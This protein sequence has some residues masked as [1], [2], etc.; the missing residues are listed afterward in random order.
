MA[1]KAPGRLT[2]RR[3]LPAYHVPNWTVRGKEVRLPSAFEKCQGQRHRYAQVKG[4][5]GTRIQAKAHLHGPE[6]V[7][8]RTMELYDVIVVGAGP[9]GAATA[10]YLARS[11]LKIL[12]LDKFEFPRDKT[13]GDALSP[14][15]LSILDNLGLTDDLRNAG[16]RVE[17]VSITSPEGK[18][19]RAPIPVH[20]VYPS[21]GYVVPRL[22]LDDLILRCGLRAG[23][24]FHGSTHVLGIER[25]RAGVTVV[26]E[27]GGSQ[28]R[29][30]ARL[31]VLAVGANVRLLQT[32]GLTPR[33]MGYAHAVRAYFEGVSGLSRSLEIRFDRAQLPGYGWIFPLSSDSANVGAGLLPRRGRK[34]PGASALLAQF[35]SDPRLG[36]RFQTAH[37]VGP[38]KGFPIRTDFQQS[39]VFSDRLVIVG[40]AAGLVNP[41]TG[42]GIDYALES[43]QLASAYLVECF[44]REDLSFE[45]LRGYERALRRRFQHVFVFSHWMRRQYMNPFLLDPLIRA[46]ERWPELT[47]LIVRT[48]LTY[49]DPAEAIRPAVLL[50]VLRCLP[51]ARSPRTPNLPATN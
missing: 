16:Y 34:T 42:E 32:L 23:V 8:Y 19:V 11:G 30:T 27:T 37:R 33:R 10:A 40:E 20:P 15:A 14:S 39:R 13:C 1:Y 49:A 18:T 25:D 36:P 46:C 28:R 5:R 29:F 51:S 21:H 22:V 17:G 38:V 26:A 48:L 9:G 41:F 50:K 4:E 12:L 3:P 6:A 47:D 7:E 44:K 43:A 31:V 35:L 2:R 24:Q 45:A